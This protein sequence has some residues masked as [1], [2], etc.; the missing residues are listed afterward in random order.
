MAESDD[1]FY[2]QAF[3][4]AGKFAVGQQMFIQKMNESK[5]ENVEVINTQTAL[6]LAELNDQTAQVYYPTQI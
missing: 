4:D 2:V 6:L 1:C 5:Y 3:L